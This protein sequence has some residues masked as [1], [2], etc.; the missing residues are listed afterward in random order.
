MDRF[1][2]IS[3]SHGAVC[4]KHGVGET[5]FALLHVVRKRFSTHEQIEG[6]DGLNM[7]YDKPGMA[8]GTRKQTLGVQVHIWT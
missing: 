3:V 1:T 6:L 2:G 4:F 7:K 5:V 8:I